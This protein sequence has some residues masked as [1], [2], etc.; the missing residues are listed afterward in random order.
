VADPDRRRR[1]RVRGRRRR[2]WCWPR[3]R[4]GIADPVGS[5]PR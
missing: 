3:R 5:T 1:P 2:C 4:A